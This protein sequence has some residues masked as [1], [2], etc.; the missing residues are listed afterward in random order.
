MI[1]KIPEKGVSE[2][3]LGILLSNAYAL[4]IHPVNLENPVKNPSIAWFHAGSET[5][6]TS[7]SSIPSR[8]TRSVAPF[9]GRSSR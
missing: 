3:R 6:S 4:E 1:D 7:A 9:C 8:A 5:S 2:T